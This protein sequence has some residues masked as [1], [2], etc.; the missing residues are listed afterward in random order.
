MLNIGMPDGWS[1]TFYPSTGIRINYG[2]PITGQTSRRFIP[3]DVRVT[4]KG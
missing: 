3:L 2:D 4:K 1:F